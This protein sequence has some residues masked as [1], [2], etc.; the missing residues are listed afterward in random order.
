[1]SRVTEIRHVGYG[2]PDLDSE[3]S[4]YK[5]VWGLKQVAARDGMTFAKMLMQHREQ[6][7]RNKIPPPGFQALWEWAK[8]KGLVT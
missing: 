7:S 1:M 3:R 2:V 4:F 5:D 6:F 8:A